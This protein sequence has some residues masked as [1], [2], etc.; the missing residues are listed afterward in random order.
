MISGRKHGCV[1]RQ[2]ELDGLPTNK[3]SIIPL[4]LLLPL[5]LPELSYKNNLIKSSYYLNHKIN[6]SER[7]RRNFLR[8]KH[9]VY[10]NDAAFQ[11]PHFPTTPLSLTCSGQ[12]R[13]LPAEDIASPHFLPSTPPSPRGAVLHLCLSVLSAWS[14]ASLESLSFS[15]YTY[16]L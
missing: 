8:T 9:L 10:L 11:L 6:F 15:A 13:F 16:S 3:V 4:T 1:Q 2:F 7:Q 12:Y 5:S 14:T